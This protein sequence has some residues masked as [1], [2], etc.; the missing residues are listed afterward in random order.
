VKFSLRKLSDCSVFP[1]RRWDIAL[2]GEVVDGRGGIAVQAVRQRASESIEVSYDCREM[3]MG[4]NGHVGVIDTFEDLLKEKAGLS[5]VCEATTLGFAELLLCCR[6]ARSAGAMSLSFVYV[7]PCSYKSP[8]RSQVV[9]RRDFE[10]T[11]DVEGYLA[12]PGAGYMLSESEEQMAVMF[13][14][15]ESQR[16]DQAFEG[17]PLQSAACSVTFG[18]PAYKF[19]WETDSF[20]N[21]VRIMCDREIVGGTEFCAAHN[22][23]AAYELLDRKHKNI[24]NKRM[25]VAPIGSKPHG[26]GV[27]LFVAEHNDVGI[28]YDHPKRMQGRTDGAGACHIFDVEF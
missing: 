12:I 14:G 1:D 16:L 21:N 28:L 13:V 18:V 26:L 10:L 23:Q 6:Y 27:A 8:R 7:E 9:H 3:T 20:A 22:P 19:G 25:F 2:I 5:I 4:I 11:N 24:G 17:L 15:Y